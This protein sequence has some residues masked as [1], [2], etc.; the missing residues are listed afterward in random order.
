MSPIP[1]FLLLWMSSLMLLSPGTDAF[2]YSCGYRANGCS[3]PGNLP[4]F[5][6][7]IFRPACNKHDQ[8]YKCGSSRRYRISRFS[9][10][11]K[12]VRNMLSICRRRF[13]H[14]A[15]GKCR[16]FA[17]LYYTAVRFG[18]RSHYLSTPESHCPWV[19]HCLN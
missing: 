5:Y 11:N 1:V 14:S 13:W 7:N 17:G 10:D 18:G 8:C 9:C 12:F 2:R 19:A 16:E 3:I 15:F 6:K 4:F